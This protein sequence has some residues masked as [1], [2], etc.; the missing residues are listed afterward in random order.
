MF[1]LSFIIIFLLSGLLAAQ[2]PHGK[3]FK[4]D[5][6]TCHNSENW[7]ITLGKL[8]FDHSKTKFSLI[9]QHNSI[10]CKACHSTLIFSEAKTECVSCHKDMHSNTVGNDCA[11][12]HEPTSWLVRN[13]NELHQLGRFPL[14]GKH[15][16]ARCE[17]C[18]IQINEL[19]FPQMGTRCFDCH[20]SD[21]YSAK[22]PNHVD[23][24]FSRECQ[25]CH[26]LS[27]VQWNVSQFAHNFFP[28]VGGHNVKTCFSCHQQNK[29]TGL[30]K[31][32]ITCHRSN[33]EAAK[34][35]D[36]I[37]NNI[38]IKCENCHSINAWQPASFNHALTTFPL[39]GAHINTQCTQCH[40]SGYG[41]ISTDCYSCHKPDYDNSKNPAHKTAGFS[42]TC[43]SCHTTNGWSPA[44]FD[45]NLTKFPLT[46]AHI[47]TQCASCHKDGYSNMSTDCYSCHKS[48]YDNSTNPNH[49]AAGF[50][51][52]C[53]PC[54]STTAWKPATFDHDAKNFPIYS[55]KHNGKWNLCSDCH[56]NNAN[57]AVF[58]CVTCHEHN[59]TDMNS[60]HQG[61]QGYVYT[62]DACL[63]CHPKGSS[64]GSFNH[65]TSIFP[66]TGAH[67]T[68]N[69]SSCHTNGYAGTPTNC[70]S[71]HQTKYNSTTN[72][73]HTTLGISTD[74]ITCH[75]TSEGWKPAQFP[76]HSTYFAFTGAHTTISNDCAKCHN[77]NYTNTSKTC[78]GCHQTKYNSTTNPNH[79][80]LGI[81]TDCITCHTTSAGWKPAQFP[82]HNTIFALV[83]AHATISNDCAKCHN[84]N[85][86]NTPKT[87]VEC[88]QTNYNNTT[89]PN[90]VAA[91]FPTDCQ[92]CH[93]TTAWKPATFDHDAKNF[94]IYSGKHNG[95]WNLCSDCHTNN[96][97]YAVFSCVTCHEHNQ[98]DMNSKHQGIQGYV[99]SSDACFSCHPK[100]S[101][102]GSFN[103]STSIFPLTG[104]HTTVTCSSCHTN[105][106][107]GTPTNCVSCHQTK[108]NSTTNPNHSTLGISTDCITCHTTSAGWK[109]AQFPI[110]NT[111][112]ALVGAHATISNDC[113]KCHNGNYTNTSKT[114]VGCH[115]TKYNSTTNPNHSALGISTDCIT[116]HTTSAGWKPAQFPI[117]NT[118][119]ALVGAHA[120][121]SNDCAKCH[122]GNYSNT[123]KTCVGCHQTNYNNTTNPNHA[124][125]GFPTDC[126]PCHSTIAWK[127][128]TFNHDGQFFP[129]YSGNHNGKWNLC[130]DCHTNNTN[131][132]VF[133]CITC[134]EHN[135]TTT[136]NNHREV[137]GYSYVS[138]ECYR[139]H[140]RGSSGGARK[141]IELK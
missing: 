128:A 108:Y 73:N 79:S 52:D 15:I 110:H 138:S 121:I 12:C 88:H 53:Q 109:P 29:F 95:K 107:A 10:A 93:S 118:I 72:P 38:P 141:S 6:G 39:T 14:V 49:I 76:T 81:S 113:A 21:Y 3:N 18:H 23:G 26:Q 45:H 58:S 86:S 47:A 137:S 123:P 130:V 42:T 17:Q 96:T 55:G 8:K 46:G 68:V 91:G 99:Y 119:F 22:S 19:K 50:P 114:C 112:F 122:N 27:D 5:C 1:R 64:E 106:Y 129:I 117:H 7:K 136:D 104:A 85:Y 97:N 11:K 74:C 34:N 82:I 84:G 37:A 115:Q 131:F 4:L 20:S 75:T 16:S 105:G 28:L 36:H 66:L 33:F 101:S 87:C 48:S 125:A 30:S 134:H 40:I 140:P 32:C 35:P 62:S 77:G 61:I 103:H 89:N 83:G 24:N 43:N 120:T 139:C 135:K 124:A 44:T 80:A 98:A 2:S 65:S 25:D 57:Y 70:V 102:E 71:C 41:K 54:H 90:H 51:T 9:G 78:V 60:K 133:S 132:A 63:S 13:I 111:I 116:C 126:Q 127:P 56:T 100:G 59:Q 92:P 94:P 69:C 31:E 67:T